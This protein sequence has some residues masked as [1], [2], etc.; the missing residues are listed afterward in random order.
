M[1]YPNDFYNAVTFELSFIHRNYYRQV[2]N[3]LDLLAD[4]GGLFSA[5]KVPFIA[6]LIVFNFYNSYQFVMMD[7]FTHGL[8]A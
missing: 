3:N 1:E 6:V 7:N 8:K 4:V 2:Y 5:L